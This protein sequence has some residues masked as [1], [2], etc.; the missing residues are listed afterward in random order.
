MPRSHWQTGR[1]SNT[2]ELAP[3]AGRRLFLNHSGMPVFSTAHCNTLS[4]GGIPVTYI[5]SKT[6]KLSVE[7]HKKVQSPQIFSGNGRQPTII[8]LPNLPWDLRSPILSFL[9]SVIVRWNVLKNASVFPVPFATIFHGEQ[10]QVDPWRAFW[11][12]RNPLLTIPNSLLQAPGF[13]TLHLCFQLCALL[14]QKK[15]NPKQNPN[16]YSNS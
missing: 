11:A 10:L 2:S 6:R 8:Y 3:N 15:K 4:P 12:S 13:I 16:N 14:L 1:N 7:T 9:L 5:M